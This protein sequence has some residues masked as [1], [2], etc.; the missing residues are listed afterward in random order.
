MPNNSVR[1]PSGNECV[2]SFLPLVS[3]VAAKSFCRGQI[4]PKTL[5]Q[6]ARCGASMAC[7]IFAV[8]VAI[9]SA[10]RLSA[11]TSGSISG[12]VADVTGAVIPDA[13]VALK[14]VGT[15]AE[16]S[17]VTTGSGDYLFPDVPPGIY[18]IKA[19]HEGFK[20]AESK[21]IEVQ[22]QQALR[23]DFTMA[24]G[25]VTQTVTVEATGALLQVENATLGTVIQNAAI[26]E[27][28][29]N[30]RNYLSLVALSSNANTLST[31]S[32]QAGSRLGGD[33][34]SQAISVGGQRIMFRSAEQ[35]Y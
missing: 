31:S 15:G 23:Q 27:L 34:A 7:C 1:H 24:V 14:N 5:R 11:Q 32:G 30:G 8:I 2:A 4:S 28:P 12:H 16:R 29:L 18:D 20:I 33:R 17:T 25:E 35:T 13:N 21:G 26:N 9:S 6:L 3:R 22:V 10:A 19:T